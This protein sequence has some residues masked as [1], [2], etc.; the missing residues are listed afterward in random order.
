M[1]PHL[2]D[3]P[4]PEYHRTPYAQAST[5]LRGP[6]PGDDLDVQ[7]IQVVGTATERNPQ[8]TT[9]WLPLTSRYPDGC[10]AAFGS[11]VGTITKTLVC[12]ESFE[13][14]DQMSF[15]EINP[16]PTARSS[17]ADINRW[18]NL[19]ISGN[20][21]VVPDGRHGQIL[22]LG[23]EDPT[24][25]RSKLKLLHRFVV[26]PET[27]HDTRGLNGFSP[28]ATYNGKLLYTTSELYLGVIDI[29]T[30]EFERGIKLPIEGGK[31]NNFP[32][33]ENGGI[34][35]TTG[36]GM[37]KLQFTGD[38][39]V[40]E[41]TAAYDSTGLS[42]N[43]FRGTGTTATLIGLGHDPDRL[44][45]FVDAKSPSNLVALWRD[46]I[47]DDWTGLDGY[48]RR[49]A[50]VHPLR[51][52]DPLSTGFAVE[53]SPVARGYD[54]ATAQSNGIVWE[55]TSCVPD[56]GVQKLTWDPDAN[57]FR[58]AWANNDI[59]INSVMTY[60][61]GSGL[62]YGVGK[63]GCDVVFYGVDWD[64]GQVALRL[65]LGGK[66]FFDGGDNLVVNDD[67]SL[68]YSPVGN[69]LVR[70]RPRTDNDPGEDGRW[71]PDA[72]RLTPGGGRSHAGGGAGRSPR[73]DPG[74]QHSSTTSRGSLPA[75]GGGARLAP[76]FA[77]GA[78]AATMRVVVRSESDH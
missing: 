16:S 44:I 58:D 20:R 23:D 41:W 2:A 53:N 11:G 8:S 70:I 54:I 73:N 59:N 69:S 56:N 19:M 32:I 3:S 31:G 33:D 10:R 29:E 21:F 30:F 74:H 9:P 78:L 37:T 52:I 24:N 65:K 1:N 45:T 67:R 6:E 50:A 15:S 26:P 43:G 14:V 39:V 12:G 13:L 36:Q 75:T 66:E 61:E 17:L 51:L 42:A 49:V 64:T 62:V 4:W 57:V 35:V 18:A 55:H 25:S 77:L 38:D 71:K 27:P 28:Q 46:E 7:F 22:V 60:S 72:I 63:E 48:D 34:Y 47:P 40:V 5:P 68:M 76:A